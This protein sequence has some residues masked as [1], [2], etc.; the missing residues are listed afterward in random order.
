MILFFVMGQE[1][2]VIQITTEDIRDY[3][4]NKHRQVDDTIYGGGAGMFIKPEPLAAAI[5]SE[6]KNFQMQK[7]FL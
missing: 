1:A 7:S 3:A 6:K 2:G 5:R 4:T